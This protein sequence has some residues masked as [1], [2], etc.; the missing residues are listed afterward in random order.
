MNWGGNASCALTPAIERIRRKKKIKSRCPF[1]I[2]TSPLT[3]AKAPPLN[4]TRAGKRCASKTANGS[5][6]KEK[7][8]HEIAMQRNATASE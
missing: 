3:S 4:L 8:F 2:L 1:G 6:G 7:R 5:C